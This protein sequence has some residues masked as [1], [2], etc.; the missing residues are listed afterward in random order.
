[1]KAL[2]DKVFLKTM[3]TIA[4]P[5]AIQNLVSSSLNMVDTLMISNLGSASIAGVGLANQVFFLYIL[6]TFGINSGGAIFIAQ[7]WGKEDVKNVNKSM[8]FAIMSSL[9]IGIVFTLAALISP[10]L[11]LG[12]FTKEA[13]VIDVGVK[14]LRIVSLSYIITA[15]SFSYSIALRTT[16]K[17]HVPLIISI[18]SLGTN[19]LLNYILIFGKFGAPALGVRGAA[20]AT[21][22]ARI[23]EFVLLLYVVYRRNEHLN[24]NLK[25]LFGWDKEFIKKYIS[26]TYPVILTEG[27]WALGQI[28]YT[29]AYAQLGKTATAS[30]QLTNTIQNMFF[31]V[32]KGLASACSIMV[33]SKIGAEEYEE[34][35]DYAMSFIVLSTVS[36]VILGLSLTLS[37][38]L[39]LKL[40][41][42]LEPLVYSSARSIIIIMG[43]TFVVRVY[44]NISI[45]GVLRSGGNTKVAMRIDLSSVWLIGVPLAFM[46]SMVLKLPVQYLFLL[47]TTEEIVKAILGFP[48]IKSKKW[49][50]NIT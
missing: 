20:I 7:Y 8:G 4:L 30:I 45:V 39:I 6:L 17:P 50:Q 13:D 46:G 24:A 5:V 43:L 37:A 14:Y 35:Y 21:V 44:N 38:D 34:A 28:M 22:I 1:M 29:I 26:V 23:V 2:K 10:K 32:V 15:I 31:V 36:G 16:G 47:I 19:T 25:E 9:I 48:I 40:F 41:N 11:I 27:F 12:I 3:L 18:I 33:G 42:N 49:I